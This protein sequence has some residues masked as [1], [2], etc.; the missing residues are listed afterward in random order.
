[1]HIHQDA[2]PAFAKLSAGSQEFES[3]GRP[4]ASAWVLVMDLAQRMA[5]KRRQRRTERQ[6]S[7]LSD[8]VLRDIGL[9]RTDIGPMAA[10]LAQDPSAGP[11]RNR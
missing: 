5:A 9:K 8:F 3:A 11:M 6:L 1:M 10:K 2:F 4:A 7:E